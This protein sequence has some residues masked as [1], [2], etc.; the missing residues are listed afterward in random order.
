MYD[1]SMDVSVD[2]GFL[3]F[4]GVRVRSKSCECR[5]WSMDSSS[6]VG[7]I[8]SGRCDVAGVVAGVDGVGID[9]GAG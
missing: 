1:L 6:M 2:R 4:V 3:I 5:E 9:A 8:G 7:K